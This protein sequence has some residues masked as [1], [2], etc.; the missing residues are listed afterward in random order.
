MH[1]Q[2]PGTSTE[3]GRHPGRYALTPDAPTNHASACRLAGRGSPT[4][5]AVWRPP[6]AVAGIGA[7]MATTPSAAQAGAG[8]NEEGAGDPGMSGV[9]GLLRHG[10]ACHDIGVY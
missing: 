6:F 4:R 3:P 8:A 9:H 5:P 7:Q 2:Y 1:G 10:W